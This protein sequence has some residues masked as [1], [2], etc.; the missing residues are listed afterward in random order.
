[1]VRNDPASVVRNHKSDGWSS[2]CRWSWPKR[3]WSYRATAAHRRAADRPNGAQVSNRWVRGTAV[4]FAIILVAGCA[5]SPDN[6]DTDGRP[7][8]RPGGGGAAVGAST[9][10]VVE[11]DGDGV[12]T[13]TVDTTSSTT[14]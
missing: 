11:T 4:L 13:T 8:V 3:V 6:V 12:T 10:T 1:C 9:T 14:S 2:T 5:A 7:A